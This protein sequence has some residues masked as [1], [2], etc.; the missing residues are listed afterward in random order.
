[1]LKLIFSYCLTAPFLCCLLLFEVGI[2][3]AEKS[4][5]ALKVWRSFLKRSITQEGTSNKQCLVTAL[6]SP[7]IWMLGKNDFE[8]LAALSSL[9]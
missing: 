9:R 4:K 6:S 5:I 8:N 2:F 1:M 3:A 7:T